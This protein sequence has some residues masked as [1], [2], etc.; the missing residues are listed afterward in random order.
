M[1]EVEVEMEIEVEVEAVV[2]V[3]VEALSV[4]QETRHSVSQV[5]A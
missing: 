5:R 4:I 3:G 1:V 2:E